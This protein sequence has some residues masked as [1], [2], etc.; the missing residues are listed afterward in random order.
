MNSIIYK[1]DFIT[2]R[3][4]CKRHGRERKEKLEDISKVISDK[5]CMYIQNTYKRLKNVSRE[6]SKLNSEETT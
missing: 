1:R 3:N 5:G 4:F 6:H 2:I